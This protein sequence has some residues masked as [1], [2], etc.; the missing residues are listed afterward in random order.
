MDLVK[1]IKGLPE[2]N[3]SVFNNL[4][5][6]FARNRSERDLS[7]IFTATFFTLLM[8]IG[9]ML[10]IFQDNGM[11]RYAARGEQSVQQ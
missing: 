1:Y 7:V 3:S 10:A 6:D 5:A 2:M 8:D 4:F 9:T 11:R